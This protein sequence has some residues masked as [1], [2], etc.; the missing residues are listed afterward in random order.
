MP[1]QINL[2]TPILLTQKR[3]FSALAMV[4][5]LALFALVGGGLAAYWV[6]SLKAASRELRTTVAAAT[7]DATKLKAAIQT[8]KAVALPPDPALVQQLQTRRLDEIRREKILF[9]LRRGL[10][11]A[12]F[13]HSDRLQ[14]VAQSIPAPVW[15]TAIREDEV[16]ME[17]SGF[18]LEP[19]ALNDW[20]ARL[21]AS[22]LMQGKALATIKVDRVAAEPQA[23][24]GLVA[25]TGTPAAAA[26]APKRPV[27]SFSLVSSAATPVMDEA[28]GKP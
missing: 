11:R 26:S 20:V 3:Y 19:S 23:A 22:P 5:A 25:A 15:V 13:G 24:A 21:A 28:K 12:G 2:C 10:F 1:Q 27:W 17:V 7:E 4:Q 6:W 16:R 14:L 8:R 9:E 18:T